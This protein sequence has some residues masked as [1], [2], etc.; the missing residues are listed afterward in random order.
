MSKRCCGLL[1]YT[2]RHFVPNCSQPFC[3]DPVM[4]QTQVR[5]LLGVNNRAPPPPHNCTGALLLCLSQLYLP[6]SCCVKL[7][8]LPS[9]L[10]VGPTPLP[11]QSSGAPLLHPASATPLINM[12]LLTDWFD[13]DEASSLVV[14]VP[15]QTDKNN[16]PLNLNTCTGHNK[17][18]RAPNWYELRFQ[19]EEEVEV[20]WELVWFRWMKGC[21]SH[22]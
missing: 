3:S 21:P 20:D 22:L 2:R 17:G 6:H 19:T 8:C 13:C 5:E 12:Q 18:E 15:H 7:C 4:C 16:T 9:H 10:S 11:H 14:E 1:N